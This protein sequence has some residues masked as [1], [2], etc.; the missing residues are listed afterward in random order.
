MMEKLR[1][2][3]AGLLITALLLSQTADPALA[4][5]GLSMP[6][7]QSGLE[8]LNQALTGSSNESRR[9]TASWMAR[10]VG[11]AA[12]AFALVF[13]TP[14]S[15][16]APLA[17]PSP[18]INQPDPVVT[19]DFDWVGDPAPENQQEPS[20]LQSALDSFVPVLNSPSEVPIPV[21]EV[22]EPELLDP[23]T[24]AVLSHSIRPD[25]P[26]ELNQP[27]PLHPGMQY[28]VES[29]EQ[30]NGYMKLLGRKL[31]TDQLPIFKSVEGGTLSS[32]VGGKVTYSGEDI[33]VAD[34]QAFV[35]GDMEV[36]VGKQKWFISAGS[37]VK[38]RIDNAKGGTTIQEGGGVEKVPEDT[39]HLRSLETLEP[40]L[41][42]LIPGAQKTPV[43]QNQDKTTRAYVGGTVKRDATGK[44]VSANMKLKP[45]GESIEVEAGGHR[46]QGTSFEF[47]METG[48]PVEVI[49]T[50]DVRQLSDQPLSQPVVPS[51]PAGGTGSGACGPPPDAAAGQTANQAS[52]AQPEVI[53]PAAA[54]QQPAGFM[55]ADSV[56]SLNHWFRRVADGLYKGWGDGTVPLP[57]VEEVEGQGS[58]FRVAAKNISDHWGRTSQV[59]FRVTP[60]EEVVL[61]H[62][63][64][65]W[66]IP[67]GE[68]ARFLLGWKELKDAK[69]IHNGMTRI[70]EMNS[71]GVIPLE[72]VPQV[73]A[74]QPAGSLAPAGGTGSG[75][76]GPPPDAAAKQAGQVPAAQPQA[77]APA[78]A[79]QP[80]I[81]QPAVAGTVP[82]LRAIESK[83]LELQATI[84]EA[85]AEYRKNEA[86]RHQESFRRGAENKEENEIA[87][88]APEQDR[89]YNAQKSVLDVLRDFLKPGFDPAAISERYEA[90]MGDWI[91]VQR[92]EAQ[93][94]AELAAQR[95]ERIRGLA[96]KKV[97]TQ[98]E[99][100]EA[101]LVRVVSE[102]EADKLREMPA[103]YHAL[104]ALGADLPLFQRLLPA[105]GVLDF[106]RMVPPP[107]GDPDRWTPGQRI[108]L[109]KQAADAVSSIL[110]GSI[111]LLEAEKVWS[112]KGLDR[113]TEL[114]KRKAL[115]DSEFDKAVWLEA[116]NQV[117][118]AQQNR[119]RA[120]QNILATYVEWLRHPTDE[121]RGQV[122]KAVLAEQEAVFQEVSEMI[123]VAGLHVAYRQREVD[124]IEKAN[125]VV[126]GTIPQSKVDIANYFLLEAQIL[127]REV[128]LIREWDENLKALG[129]A[130]PSPLSATLRPGSISLE[131]WEALLGSPT[132]GPG[133][134]ANQG[135][136]ASG[137]GSGQW[138]AEEL[139]PPIDPGLAQALGEEET[140]RI[141][142][143]QRAIQQELISLTI[144][145]L[146]ARNKYHRRQANRIE[147]L[148]ERMRSVV[149]RDEFE[150]KVLDQRRQI[151]RREA[152]IAVKKQEL[153][154]IDAAGDNRSDQLVMEAIRRGE[155]RVGQRL[156]DLKGSLERTGAATRAVKNN[157]TASETERLQVSVTLLESR[158]RQGKN[159]EE[160]DQ[161]YRDHDYPIVLPGQSP[162]ILP[163]LNWLAKPPSQ[164]TLP[165][166][167][168]FVQVGKELV[169][170]TGGQGPA[171]LHN[172]IYNGGGSRWGS[173]P[174]VQK[175][176]EDIFGGGW[177]PGERLIRVFANS[178]DPN[179]QSKESIGNVWISHSGVIPEWDMGSGTRFVTREGFTLP[180]RRPLPVPGL[181]AGGKEGVIVYP[182]YAQTVEEGVV[183]RQL[184]G[185]IPEE[186]IPFDE[187]ER[188]VKQLANPN[189]PLEQFRKLEH[190]S[191][192]VFRSMTPIGGL[193]RDKKGNPVKVFQGK[194]SG[195]YLRL[196]R[197]KTKNG[198]EIRWVPVP[199][200]TPD[201]TSSATSSSAHV[202]VVSAG[203]ANRFPDLSHLAGRMISVDGRSRLLVLPPGATPDQLAGW[204]AELAGLPE[205]VVDGYGGL[206]EDPELHSLVDLLKFSGIP[207]V[208]QRSDQT[209]LSALAKAILAALAGLEESA[210]SEDDVSSFL[211]AL[212]TAA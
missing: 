161:W 53:T 61:R 133:L 175:R 126:Q 49:P 120:Q 88:F 139:V 42:E 90:A 64:K 115:T 72:L 15:V 177:V 91:R 29:E 125:T 30:M 8:E 114:H 62:R 40:Y 146:E 135:L 35:P 187:L 34:M 144:E 191:D 123:K 163:G 160:W 55:Q 77:L 28:R 112:L 132:S 79:A 212:T 23:E 180:D 80:Q 124:R 142:N 182:Q 97:A 190:D 129:Q 89:V 21:P 145:R 105:Q 14:P 205:V 113:A 200:T 60:Q 78:A 168:L 193:L 70:F 74:G 57:K 83:I 52:A 86:K 13:A 81:D 16:Q 51:T 17:S 184:V 106:A 158:R 24:V 117:R 38:F 118:T 65:A 71:P 181:L 167:P 209:I 6:E 127:E 1:R 183:K 31:P 149:S 169:P 162:Q 197:I 198:E 41:G 211:N 82:A 48:K 96:A 5:R 154:R 141:L 150:E 134:V 39:P 157:F 152:E 207:Y 110:N 7:Q 130:V 176:P 111:R 192:G 208:P 148:Y 93:V 84:F 178:R 19:L 59:E 201:A 32:D 128:R 137:L 196:E 204:V 166:E 67:A 103:L 27:L 20:F 109:V 87:Q 69:G 43:F 36:S 46:W 3:C 119:L 22:T 195:V 26:S 107:S 136:A 179:P 194:G 101:E 203:T 159:Q 100:E 171:T 11:A 199:V 172:V 185:V 98:S 122:E 155:E 10:W 147:R 50:D 58:P 66:R 108:L 2:L 73:D 54:A 95:E 68:E 63:D 143:S 44:I 9:S 156:D 75:A 138:R 189:T 56:V 202:A 94:R 99:V 173:G 45:I 116:Q 76:G 131:R 102:V 165:K 153:E 25:A 4:L 121:T 47:Q 164:Q 170:I 186:R 12:V 18:A 188:L 37:V 33:R 210:I 174:W 140:Q 206:E 85:G 92:E 151:D 104:W